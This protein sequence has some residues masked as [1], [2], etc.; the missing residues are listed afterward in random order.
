[1]SRDI[2]KFIVIYGPSNLGKTEQVSRLVIRLEDLL[3]DGVVGIKYP[4]YD[5]PT[6]QRINREI[7]FKRTMSEE[8][9]QQE[10]AANRRCY[11]PE[12]VGNLGNSVWVVAEDYT[13]TG[14]I[15]GLAHGVSHDRLIEMNEDL[16]EPDLAVLLDGERYTSG[17]ERG[18]HFEGGGKWETARNLHLEFADSLGWEIVNANQNME[19]VESDIWKVVENKFFAPK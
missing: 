5:T 11:E 7:R 9:L 1:M 8:E 19:K 3:G 16:K 6:G 13:Y 14:I 18:H 2:G 12:L 10:Y 17:I 15:W 4:I